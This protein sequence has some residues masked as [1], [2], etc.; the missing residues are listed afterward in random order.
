MKTEQKHK[1]AF[2]RS[3]AVSVSQGVTHKKSEKI[4]HRMQGAGRLPQISQ[5]T[6]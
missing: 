6:I 1:R 3:R 2:N 4:V 5:T